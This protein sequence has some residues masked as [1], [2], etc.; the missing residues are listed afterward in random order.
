MTVVP[1]VGTWIEID[2]MCRYFVKPRVV[3]YV[4]T[5]IEIW[6]NAFC[7]ARSMVVPYVGTWIEIHLIRYRCIGVRSF[8]TW[9]RG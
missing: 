6:I 2:L 1:Y 8:P 7:F 9:E 3:P 4:G 5:W